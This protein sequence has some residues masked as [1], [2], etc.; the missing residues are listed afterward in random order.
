MYLLA[1]LHYKTTQIKEQLQ[2]HCVLQEIP[3]GIRNLRIELRH[4]LVKN[5]SRR[6]SAA[7]CNSCCRCWRLWLHC[8]PII[9]TGAYSPHSCIKQNRFRSPSNSHASYERQLMQRLSLLQLRGEA[10]SEVC[11]SH[12]W[13]GH[14]GCCKT[15]EQYTVYREGMPK[16]SDAAAP[17]VST[18]SSVVSCILQRCCQGQEAQATHQQPCIAHERPSHGSAAIQSTPSPS[19]PTPAT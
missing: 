6:R 9:L 19:L 5:S 18:T 14:L 1:W 10:K 3:T 4:Y 11:C 15:T 16:G 13:L 7:H 8:Q 2:L 12:E 17:C